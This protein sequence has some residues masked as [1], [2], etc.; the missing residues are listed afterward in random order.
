MVCV[1]MADFSYDAPAELFMAASQRRYS[2]LSY[3]RFDSA[4]DAIRYAIEVLPASVLNGTVLEVDEK[5]YDAGLIRELY[6]SDAYPLARA[7][8][9]H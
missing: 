9:E 7:R 2:S 5:R 6:E 3:K 4:A 1:E 8:L